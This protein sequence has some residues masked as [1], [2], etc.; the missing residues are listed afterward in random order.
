M[1]APLTFTIALRACCADGTQNVGPQ[2]GVVP[3][4][5]KSPYQ[6]RFP[7]RWRC[8]ALRAIA[9]LDGAASARVTLVDLVDQRLLTLRLA[10]QR[11]LQHLDDVAWCQQ[12]QAWL[13][14]DPLLGDE[15]HGQHHHADVVVPGPPAHDLVIGET[16]LALGVLESP[17]N[18]VALALHLGQAFQ[19]C[20]S[21]RVGQAVLDPL[22]R[23]HLA[24]DDQM[25]APRRRFL[26]APPP[27]PPMRDIAP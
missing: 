25:P 6:Q 16:A 2:N 22:R 10:W 21:R 8:S 19:R 20:V 12:R 4:L 24:A 17:L 26:A 23:P 15:Q 18:P 14:C 3:N 7:S 5:T 1:R 13:M 11:L 9:G 27:A